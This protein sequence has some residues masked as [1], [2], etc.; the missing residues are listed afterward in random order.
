MAS[1]AECPLRTIR[2]R[3]RAVYMLAVKVQIGADA[4]TGVHH[5][6]GKVGQVAGHGRDLNLLET[7]GGGADAQQRGKEVIER[8]RAP[9]V[10]IRGLPG[11]AG[12]MGREVL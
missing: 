1:I 6:T 10:A 4:A 3:N 2:Q 12:A 7:E 9:A 5:L 11:S 8:V